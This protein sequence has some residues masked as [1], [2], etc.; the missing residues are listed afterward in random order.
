MIHCDHIHLVSNQSHYVIDL[1]QLLKKFGK[2]KDESF[3]FW[4]QERL[5]WIGFHK[6]QYNNQC[7]LRLLPK[8]I[9]VTI[10]KFLRL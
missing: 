2:F 9:L 1:K 8:D 10:L 7:Q 6:N 3:F 5:L 4:K